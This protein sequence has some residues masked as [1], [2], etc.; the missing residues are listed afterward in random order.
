MLKILLIANQAVAVPKSFF[1]P[2]QRQTNYAKLSNKKSGSAF[3][4]LAPKFH[5][6]KQFPRKLE[7]N[8]ITVSNGPP[9]PK[10]RQNMVPKKKKKQNFSTW[11][12]L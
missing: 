7:F 1:P 12:E 9:G 10:P 11:M 4:L 6:G 2:I 3:C 8:G 5:V